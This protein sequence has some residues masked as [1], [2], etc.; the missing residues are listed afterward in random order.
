MQDWSSDVLLHIIQYLN[1]IDSG[2]FG[3]TSR[4]NFYLVHHYRDYYCCRG[5]AE[6]VASICDNNCNYNKLCTDAVQKLQ[7][8]PKFGIAFTTARQN[9]NYHRFPRMLPWYVPDDTVL[10][11]ATAQSIQSSGVSNSENVECVSNASLF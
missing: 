4:R 2:R 3:I 10:L 6:L 11:C 7:T 9:I 1:I 5:G 8:K